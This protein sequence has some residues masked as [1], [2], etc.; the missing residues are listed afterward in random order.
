MIFA[1]FPLLSAPVDGLFSYRQPD[2]KT[3]DVHVKGD[4]CYAREETP[5]GYLII[6]DPGTKYWCYAQVSKDGKALESTGIVVGRG[7]PGLKAGRAPL[8]RHLRVPSEHRRLLREANLQR[9]HRDGRGRIQSI[10][11]LPEPGSGSPAPAALQP[12][13][14]LVTGEKHGLTLL[15]RFPDRGEDVTIS[16]DQVD[17]FCNQLTPHYSEFGN[18]GS[19]AEYFHEVSGGTLNYRNEVTEYYTARNP[20][21]YYTDESIPYGSRASDLIREALEDLEARGFD[22]RSADSNGD[23]VIDALNCFYAGYTTNVWAKGLWPHASGLWWVSAKTQVQSG[24]YQ[25]TDM[26]AGLTLGTFCHENGHMLCGFPDVYDYDYDSCGGAGSFCLMDF[27]GFGTNP[28]PPN[29]YLRYRAGWGTAQEIVAGSDFT[30]AL[31]AQRDG[32]LANEFLI[33]VNPAAGTELYLIENRFKGDRDLGLATGGIAI[34]HVD[35]FGSNSSQSYAHQST[36]ANYQIALIQAD[37]LRDFERNLSSGDPQDLFYAGNG[38]PGYSNAFSDASDGGPYDNN[39]HWWDGSASGLRLSDFSAP[40]NL[41][42]FKVG[43]S[44][45]VGIV[46]LESSAYETSESSASIAVRVTR[47]GGSRGPASVQFA[48]VDGSARAGIDYGSASGTLAWADGESGSRSIQVPLL[49]QA[50]T[51]GN[52]SLELRL[53]SA[54]GASL[55]TASAALTILDDGAVNL[56]PRRIEAEAFTEQSGIQI[57]NC[58]EGGQNLG[59]IDAGDWMV[60]PITVPRTGVYTLSY[61]VASQNEGGLLSAD[62]DEGAVLFDSMAISNTGGWQNWTTISQTATLGEGSHRFRVL[63]RS[64]G[65]NLDW[66]QFEILDAPPASLHLEAEA[67]STMSGVQSAPCSEGGQYIGWIDAG[68]WMVYPIEVPTAGPYLIR[69]RV[70][71]PGDTTLSADLNAGA[72]QLGELAIPATGGWENWNTLTQVVNLPA[73]TSNLGIFAKAGGWNLNWIELEPSR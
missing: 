28:C 48:T 49:S 41:M 26:G 45:E 24:A 68:D 27:G 10:N 25:I 62:L 50:A 12:R 65:W 21:D 39:A 35:E 19:V 56:L 33:Q 30:A 72:T 2:G 57:E 3:I 29:G 31:T 69:Y 8:V 15:I 71:A 5:D 34:W 61:R 60:Y 36:H 42:T 32:L 47:S 64:G 23:G 6:Q 51:L 44:P 63:A 38:A 17:R 40:G 70:S 54:S 22:F 53:S 20:R 66:I 67:F 4:E 58:A 46:G 73:G 7:T 13:G 18:N 59:W 16:R 11:A 52:R 37:N 1:S 14:P 55:G 43:S 9:L